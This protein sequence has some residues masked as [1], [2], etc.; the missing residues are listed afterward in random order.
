MNNS[1]PF[2]LTLGG[3]VLSVGGGIIAWFMALERRMNAMLLIKDHEQICQNANNRTEK[4]IEALKDTIEDHEK[5][6]R[7]DRQEVRDALNDLNVK[8]AAIVA[9]SEQR[10]RNDR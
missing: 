5:T 7:E 3:A 1:W 4:A 10:R 6:N 9:R 8:V 2:L